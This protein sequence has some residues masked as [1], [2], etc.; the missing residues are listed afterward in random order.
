MFFT[1]SILLPLADKTKKTSLFPPSPQKHLLGTAGTRH[2]LSAVLHLLWVMSTGQEQC[3]ME[4][5]VSTSDW[6]IESLQDVKDGYGR[7]LEIFWG[8]G[9]LSRY[10]VPVL[11]PRMW[12]YTNTGCDSL[13]PRSQGTKNAWRIRTADVKE[14]IVLQEHL[15]QDKL[16]TEKQ[17][18]FCH[19][20]DA[21]Y[22]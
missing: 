9:G 21:A 18:V 15:S 6:H 14:P 17:F 8:W 13:T 10:H 1:T 2:S 3:L 5:G 12:G 11:Y 16:Y 7:D 19:E 4:K 20:T 22:T